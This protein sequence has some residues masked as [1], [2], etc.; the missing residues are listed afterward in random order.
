MINMGTK[1]RKS[2]I[3]H[4]LLFLK[5]LDTIMVHLSE[6]QRQEVK[7]SH[8][9]NWFPNKWLWNSVYLFTITILNTMLTTTYL[10]ND[11]PIIEYENFWIVL[12]YNIYLVNY[13][14]I[15]LFFKWPWNGIF[16]IF[17]VF[18]P[19]AQSLQKSWNALLNSPHENN[20]FI[21]RG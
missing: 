2:Q 8:M 19:S 14:L 18:I 21:L 3:V 17:M 13:N 16:I 15:N 12:G 5:K 1:S 20:W 9:D 10:G 11:V 7:V 4:G 6:F